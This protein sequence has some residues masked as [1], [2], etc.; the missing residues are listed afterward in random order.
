MTKGIDP[1]DAEALMEMAWN[2]NDQVPADFDK[3]AFTPEI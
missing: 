1:A 3:Y 2:D